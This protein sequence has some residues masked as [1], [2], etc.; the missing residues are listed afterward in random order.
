MLSLS[1][2]SMKKPIFYGSSKIGERGQVVIPKRARKALGMK[3]GDDII[4]LG[5][6]EKH[7]VLMKSS[8]LD[9]WLE[10]FSNSLKELRKVAKVKR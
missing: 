10:R 9:E 5:F 7:L 8:A 2:K 6:A 3:S 4:F 1:M